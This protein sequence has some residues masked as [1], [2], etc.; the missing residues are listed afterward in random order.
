[1]T[2]PMYNNMYR[3]KYERYRLEQEYKNQSF[4]TQ[5]YKIIKNK[6]YI[7]YLY[8]FNRP[9]YDE[10]MKLLDLSNKLKKIN[11]SNVKNT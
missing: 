5:I 1:M 8:Y 4:I 7:T 9:K 2:N 3:L 6:C 11:L 10:Y